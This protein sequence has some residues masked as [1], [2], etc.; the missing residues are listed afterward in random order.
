MFHPGITGTKPDYRM[1][2]ESIFDC[3][4][5]SDHNEMQDP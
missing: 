3:V 1:G 4:R 2:V 5:L